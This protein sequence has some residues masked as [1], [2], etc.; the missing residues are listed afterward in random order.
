MARHPILGVMVN[1]WEMD[2]GS[3]SR[4]GTFF[5]VTTAQ[6]FLPRRETPVRPDADVAALK[7]YSIWYSR[8]C[9]E[10]IEMWWS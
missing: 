1:M 3:M 4:S 10:K 9:G 8:P 7:A 2:L 5:W 6:E